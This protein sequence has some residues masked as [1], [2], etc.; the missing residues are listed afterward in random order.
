MRRHEEQLWQQ[1]RDGLTTCEQHHFP[2]PG[3]ADPAHREVFL[4]QLVDSIRRVQ[5]VRVVAGRHINPERANGQSPLFDPIRAA[6]LRRHEGQFDEA[7]WLAFLFV[8]FGRHPISGYRYVREFYGALGQRPPWTFAAVSADPSA[9]RN[10]LDANEQYLR[11]GNHRGFGN[12][13][14]YVSLSGSR[15]NGTGDAFETYVNWAGAH[16]GHAALLA[17]AAAAAE[18]DPE[19]AFEWLY[20][21]MSAVV[22]YGRIGKFDYLTMLQKLGF[23]DIRPGRPYLYAN[24]NGPN[25]GARIMFGNAPVLK[26]KQLEERVKILGSCLGVGMQEMEDSLCNWGKDPTHYTYFRG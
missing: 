8:H 11:R 2:L 4:H 14:K 5:F 15:P 24:T 6:L 9:M 17:E 21:S 26:A 1:L 20:R 22:S 13:R 3:V 10:W 18:G 25:T 23:A 16:G 7:C 19:S 12:H